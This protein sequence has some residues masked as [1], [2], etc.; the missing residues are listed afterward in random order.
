MSARTRNDTAEKRGPGQPTKITRA[1]IDTIAKEI[2]SGAPSEVA[3]GA[4]GICRATYFNWLQWGR[5]GKGPIYREFLD[6]IERAEDR[7]H[8]RLSRLAFVGGAKS[9]QTWWLARKHRGLWGRDIREDD[10]DANEGTVPDS[11]FL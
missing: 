11:V 4:N 5:E 9:S 1:I 2:E 3:A 10:G 7:A 6:A 8:S